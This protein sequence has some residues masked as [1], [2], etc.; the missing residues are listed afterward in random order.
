MTWLC[1]TIQV[2]NCHSV[3][4]DGYFVHDRECAGAEPANSSRLGCVSFWKYDN[5]NAF[6]Q[7]LLDTMCEI[8]DTGDTR[9]DPDRAKRSPKE[10]DQRPLL[11][12]GLCSKPRGV[13]SGQ[14]KG[15]ISE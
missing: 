15:Q 12:F 7:F 8:A 6:L 14:N 9:L 10:S 4:V 5:R 1:V 2:V 11:K 13:H 3:Q